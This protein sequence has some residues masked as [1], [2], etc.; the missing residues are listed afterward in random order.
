MAQAQNKQAVVRR[1]EIAGT[2]E[3]QISELDPTGSAAREAAEIQSA[4]MIAK[5]FPRDE[6]KAR[7]RIVSACRRLAFAD[8]AYCS[9]PRGDNDVSGASVVL[10]REAARIWGN[11]RFGLKI[12]RDDDDTRTIKGWALDL[13]SNAYD[14]GE[15]HFKKLI[16]RK[17]QGGGT[18]WKTPDERDLRELTNRRG[19]ILVRNAIMSIMPKDMIDSAVVAAGETIAEY[20]DKDKAETAKRILETFS[21]L[22]VTQ[23]ELEGYLGHSFTDLT[24]EEIV[25]L[26]GI[27]GALRSGVAKKEEFFGGTKPTENG[28]GLDQSKM[29]A[30]NAEH[31][32]DHKSNSEQTGNPQPEDTKAETETRVKGRLF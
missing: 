12:I 24:K 9:F 31:Y 27:A 11:I 5:R 8:E 15:D 30:G 17:A 6:E 28:G 22:F 2:Q 19:S 20:A 32:D 29:K 13:E 23:A 3:T 1:D 16:Q 7:E 10:G 18:V 21:T 26:R 25:K 4:Y 14:E